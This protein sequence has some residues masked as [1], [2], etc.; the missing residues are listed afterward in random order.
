MSFA[1]S[2]RWQH[3]EKS[4]EDAASRTRQ[5]PAEPLAVRVTE[6]VLWVGATARL[7]LRK[8][9]DCTDGQRRAEDLEVVPIDLVLQAG[10][11][12][13]IQTDE[14]LQAV[15][16]TIRHHE[17]MELHGKSRLSPRLNW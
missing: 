15:T 2:D 13:L 17:T 10:I 16:A 6:A 1:N 7:E 8:A 14:L 5:A 12:R 3:I 9:R 11:T 4:I